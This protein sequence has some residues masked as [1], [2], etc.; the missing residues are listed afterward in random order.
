M[1]IIWAALI[2]AA[3]LFLGALLA[4]LVVVLIATRIDDEPETLFEAGWD[5]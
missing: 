5:Q 4:F 1:S 3:G 2:F